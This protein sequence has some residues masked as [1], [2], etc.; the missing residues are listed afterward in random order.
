[1]KF[2]ILLLFLLINR[3]YS[4][5]QNTSDILLLANHFNDS[6][7]IPVNHPS[8]SNDSSKRVYSFLIGKLYQQLISDQMQGKCIFSPSCS[9]YAKQ[10]FMKY[11][12]FKSSLL[13]IDR[14]NRCHP[15]NY[16]SYFYAKKDLKDKRI[17]DSP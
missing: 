4:Y 3:L 1:M 14:L 13:T 11:G 12:M 17:M 8:F 6:V 7:G 15:R 2:R 9:I 5:S 16:S 10:C